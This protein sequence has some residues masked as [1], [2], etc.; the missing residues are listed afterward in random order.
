ML[1][2][3]NSALCMKYTGQW[4]CM[5]N[6]NWT[7]TDIVSMMIGFY[8]SLHTFSPVHSRFVWISMLCPCARYPGNKDIRWRHFSPK[9]QKVLAEYPLPRIIWTWVGSPIVRIAVLKVIQEAHDICLFKKWF[10]AYHSLNSLHAL[11]VNEIVTLY[12]N[13]VKLYHILFCTQPLYFSE[14]CRSYII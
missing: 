1:W 6:F 13:Y 7:L 4:S 9:Y 2:R 11:S 8:S 12:Y 5:A 14:I 3:F 10:N